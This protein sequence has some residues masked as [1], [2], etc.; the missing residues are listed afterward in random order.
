MTIKPWHNWTPGVLSK[1]QMQELRNSGYIRSVQN[2]KKAIDDSSIDLTLSN[3]VYRLT[4]GSV[5]PFEGEHYLETLEPL[6]KLLS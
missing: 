3:E 6:A 2:P 1:R 4:V 5:K